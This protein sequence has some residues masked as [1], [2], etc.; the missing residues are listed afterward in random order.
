MATT[1]PI[2][3]S[4][5]KKWTAEGKTKAQKRRLRYY[6]RHRTEILSEFKSPYR[7]NGISIALL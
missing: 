5:D 4:Q 6:Y 3:R 2:V 7:E 1:M